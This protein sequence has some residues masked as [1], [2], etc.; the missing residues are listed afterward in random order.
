[1][2]K[3]REATTTTATRI[4][5]L[6]VYYFLIFQ[7][8]LL[9][10]LSGTVAASAA[11]ATGAIEKMESGESS[12]FP[13]HPLLDP[14]V[15]ADE[16]WSNNNNPNQ[17]QP[18]VN[19]DGVATPSLMDL[20][21]GLMG[22]DSTGLLAGNGDEQQPGGSSSGGGSESGPLFDPTTERN[23][24][25]L[26]GRTANLHCRVR[27]LGNRTVSWIRHRD[28]HILTVGR[29]TY[30]SDQRFTIVKSRPTEDWTLQI[31]FTQARDAGLYECQVSTQPHRSQ[32]IRLNV[33]DDSPVGDQGHAASTGSKSSKL[34]KKNL[35]QYPPKA[36]ILGG[37]EFHVDVGSHVNLTCIVQFSPEPPEYVFW[38]HHDQELRHDSSRGGVAIVTDKTNP[39]TSTSLL[40]RQ[41]RLSDS[42]KYSCTPSNADPASVTLH[43]LQGERPAAMQSNG[44]SP[45]SIHWILLLFLPLLCCR[46]DH[47]LVAWIT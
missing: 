16:P 29:Y 23:V 12:S 21:T 2:K 11:E 34:G 24:T 18:V 36:V 37:P 30:A 41:V 1:M 38:H 27:Y 13:S 6:C 3:M 25:V 5:P 10:L 28:V 47:R 45:C 9:F 22:L 35:A 17:Q 33:V 39:V 19:G 31:K 8:S 15:Q 4:A 44:A 7:T 42:G 20:S 14:D 26:V 40:L 46:F 43:V 32:F